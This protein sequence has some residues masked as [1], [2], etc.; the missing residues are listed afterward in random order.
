MAGLY[1]GAHGMYTS[2]IL[3]LKRKFGQWQEDDANM[4]HRDLE[5]CEYVEA[6]KLTGSVSVP[7]GQVFM[8]FPFFFPFN[9]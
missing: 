3:H 5:F 4:K 9:T 1:V 6:Y 8:F 7:A 2:E